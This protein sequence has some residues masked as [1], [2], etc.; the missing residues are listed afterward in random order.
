P[1]GGGIVRQAATG[2]FANGPFIEV[3][4]PAARVRLDGETWTTLAEDGSLFRTFSRGT[5]RLE[6]RRYPNGTL[7]VKTV[8]VDPSGNGTR[9]WPIPLTGL[10]PPSV[11]IDGLGEPWAAMQATGV[12]VYRRGTVVGGVPILSGLPAS[13]EQPH[14]AAGGMTVIVA[15]PTISGGLDIRAYDRPSLAFVALPDSGAAPLP[16]AYAIDVDPSGRPVLA[17]IG[18]DEALHIT[19]FESNTWSPVATFTASPSTLFLSLQLRVDTTGAIVLVA[20]EAAH[21]P[22]PGT[23]PAPTSRS[24]LRVFRQSGNTFTDTS[25]TGFA[26]PIVGFVFDLDETDRP[27]VAFS[28]GDLTGVVRAP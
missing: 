8:D 28:E 21:T 26:G 23:W 24:A 18:A 22:A 13:S 16:G 2:L 1:V 5:M 19:R 17:W 27:Y 15:V 6:G 12:H 10:L 9:F 11:A 25:L 3:V 20:H 14:I 7:E 4:A